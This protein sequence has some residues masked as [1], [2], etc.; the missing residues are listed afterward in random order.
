MFYFRFNRP[1]ASKIVTRALLYSLL[2]LLALYHIRVPIFQLYSEHCFFVLLYAFLFSSTLL[3]NIYICMSRELKN[4]YSTWRCWHEP[5]F[6][7]VKISLLNDCHPI[8]LLPRIY[9]CLILFRDQ[10]NCSQTVTVHMLLLLI[11][12]T[13]ESTSSNMLHSLCMLLN[14]VAVWV[15]SC[16]LYTSRCV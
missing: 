6:L 10:G 2:S 14:F 4:K 16:L 5:W 12:T 7:N 11:L 3:V 8:V 9:P 1:I 15:Y 13:F